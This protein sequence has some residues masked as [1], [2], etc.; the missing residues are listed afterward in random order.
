[1]L[2]THREAA[3]GE[4]IADAVETRRRAIIV[5]RFWLSGSDSRSFCCLDRIPGAISAAV[6]LFLG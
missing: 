5:V 1:M 6:V 2:R 3:L 4:R